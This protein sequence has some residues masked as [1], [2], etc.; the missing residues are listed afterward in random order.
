MQPARMKSML[1]KIWKA[2]EEIGSGIYRK[3]AELNAEYALSAE[4]VP[5]AE[6]KN[7]NYKKIAEGETWSENLWDCAWFRFY[8]N[9]PEEY[10][11]NCLC[12][13]IDLDGEGCLFSEDGTPVRGIT[14]VSSEF[15]RSL[16][17]PGKRY[18]PFADGTFRTDKIDLWVEAGNNDLFGRFCGGKLRQAGIYYC[19]IELRALFYD[20]NVLK[21][22]AENIDERD[23]L[24]MGILYALEKVA[25]NVSASSGTEKI[26]EMRA[27]LAEYL[28]RKGA[29]KP[30]L[31]FYAVGHSHLDL[32]WLW[33]IRETKRKAGRTFSTA[34]ANIQ[35]YPDYIYGASQPQQFEWMKE[36]YPRLFEKIKEQVAAGKIEVQGGMWVEPDTNITGGESLIRQFYYGKKFW[37][38]E[39]SKDVNTLWLPDVFGFTGALPQ[40][41]KGCDCENM[42]TIKIC[43]NMVN[44]FPYHS[45]L[46]QGID[47]S[48][49]LVH[50]PPEGTYNSSATPRSI[51]NAA[52]EYAERGIAD[53]AMILYGI[54]DGGGG[55]NRSH[56]EYLKREKDLCNLP[57]VKSAPS[58]EFFAKLNGQREKLPRYKG[59]IYLERHQGTYTSQSKNK[60]YNRLIENALART[61]YIYALTQKQDGAEELD[62][63]WKEVLLYQF[64]DILPG[65]S[66]ARVY[67]ETEPRYKSLLSLL[68]KRSREALSVTGKRLCAVNYTSFARNEYLKHGGEWYRAEAKP[69]GVS[70]LKKVA[71]GA[72]GTCSAQEKE[73][74]VILE[75]SYVRAEINEAGELTRLYDKKAD[76]ESVNGGNVLR[77]YE[78][79]FD[80]WDFYAGYVNAESERFKAVSR[81]IYN[82]GFEAGVKIT[83]RYGDSV[84]VQ[85]ICLKEES[86]AV[87]FENEAEW[88][89]TKKML[90]V[91]FRPDIFTD[92]VTCDIQFGNIKRRTTENNGI[93]WAQYEICAHK[94]I[95]ASELEYGV[96]ILNDCKYGYRAKNGLISLNLLRSQMYPCLNQDKGTQKFTYAVLPHSGNVYESDVAKTAY[97]LNRPLYICEAA[98]KDSFA[99][100]NNSH[101]I[102]ETVKRAYDGAGNILRLYNDTPAV[103]KAKLAGDFKK[104]YET[105]FLENGCEEIA[106]DLIFKPYEIKTLKLR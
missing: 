9:V 90:R 25:V 48:E 14:N 67:N 76:R 15:D 78:D 73:G 87:Y 43:W 88:R 37:K 29:E 17:F 13:G 8:G 65:A 23:P 47:G 36:Q 85:K 75:N 38:D 28:E 62:K 32:A 103:Q 66:I 95:D 6:R 12:L 11:K 100:T 99:S 81:E 106:P 77:V 60:R 86:A 63:I 61:E 39:F 24:K 34:L 64:H 68:D 72:R 22:L 50:M 93:E 59:E 101:V 52:G 69:F 94:W 27:V 33:P 70:A 19:N 58:T 46:W 91:D 26:R 3:I 97:A 10:D 83:Y 42:L 44:K 1:E 49:V 79:A 71:V 41:M 4:P 16:G 56:L 31:T 35:D 92:E 55:P 80:A 21:D 2:G 5:F 89:E 51:R 20:F 54:G 18:I 57:R 53:C 84:I 105:N 45:F 102:I 104:L 82:D 30:A 74:S 40:I 96:A 98:E 7:L